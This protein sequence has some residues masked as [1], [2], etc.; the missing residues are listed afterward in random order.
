[1]EWNVELLGKSEGKRHRW[2]NNIKKK[3]LK[4]SLGSNELN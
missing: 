4:D 3:S 1:M 2:E